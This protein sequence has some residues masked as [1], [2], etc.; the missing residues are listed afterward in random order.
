M[1]FLSLCSL[2]FCNYLRAKQDDYYEWWIEKDVE[3]SS[4]GLFWGSV[5]AFAWREENLKKKK[6]DLW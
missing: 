5:N 4:H 2:F 6:T 1:L 3:G